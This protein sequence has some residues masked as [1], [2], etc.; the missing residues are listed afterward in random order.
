MGT[1]LQLPKKIFFT[2]MLHGLDT[3][4]F[5]YRIHIAILL[6]KNTDFDHIT[7]SV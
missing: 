5:S 4:A 7:N 6:L 3:T 2:K 1:S